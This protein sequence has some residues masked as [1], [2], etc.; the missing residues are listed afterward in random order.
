MELYMCVLLLN[1]TKGNNFK[2]ILKRKYSKHE[3]CCFFQNTNSILMVAKCFFIFAYL[4]N[5]LIEYSL[6]LSSLQALKPL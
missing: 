2:T 3:I 5:C 6:L 1:V 4:L